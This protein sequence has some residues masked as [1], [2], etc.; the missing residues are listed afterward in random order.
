AAT[1]AKTKGVSMEVWRLPITSSTRY[2]VEAGSTRP[3]LRLTTIRTKPKASR[4]RRD[5]MSSR[6]SG[7]NVRSRSERDG[8]SFTFVTLVPAYRTPEPGIGMRTWQRGILLVG[9]IDVA[10]ANCTDYRGQCCISR[11]G[12]SRLG[13]K[14]GFLFPH[15][16][17]RAC[18]RV[19]CHVYRCTLL[20]RKSESGSARR[21]REPLGSCRLHDSRAA[22]RLSAGIHGSQGVLDNWWRDDSLAGG[23]LV[24]RRRRAADL[25]G[26]RAW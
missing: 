18:D 17:G 12:H 9:G 16:A 2:L 26:L 22:Q 20:G 6:M 21:S 3:A 1:T 8:F 5:P 11:S 10:R 14:C 7:S 15:G 23:H 24:R 19:L 13:R 25:A 4:P